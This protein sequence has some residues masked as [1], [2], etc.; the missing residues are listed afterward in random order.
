MRRIGMGNG[1]RKCWLCFLITYAPLGLASAASK[2]M[3]L[4]LYSFSGYTFSSEK[5]TL[6]EQNWITYNPESEYHTS[7]YLFS[8]I[9]FPFTNDPWSQIS[10][11]LIT[12]TRIFF[13][14]VSQF[15]LIGFRIIW[16]MFNTMQ[17][18]LVFA[19][20]FVKWYVCSTTI[21]FCTLWKVLNIWL[22]NGAVWS[23]RK[24]YSF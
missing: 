7:T 4:Y 23:K 2:Q 17:K 10:F 15:N 24:W 19:D 1:A 8:F 12:A 5:W 16:I 22:K 20:L 9:F 14:L 11:L 21:F 3:I 18:Y 13:F 6:G